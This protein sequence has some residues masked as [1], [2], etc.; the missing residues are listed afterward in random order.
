MVMN[1]LGF[2]G[3]VFSV[4]DDIFVGYWSRVY[5]RMLIGVSVHVSVYVVL[6]NFKKKL[7]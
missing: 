6:C 1:I 7:E 2:N 3:V 4:V 5:V